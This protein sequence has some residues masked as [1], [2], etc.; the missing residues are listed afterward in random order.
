MITTEAT[1]KPTDECYTPPWVFE[2]L[3]IEFDLD[4]CAPEGGPPHVPA[5]RFF[6]LADD[7]LTS[8]WGNGR[9]WMNPP[10]SKPQPWIERFVEHHNG[11][12]LVPFSK[13]RWFNRLWT[14]DA[15]MVIAP[16]NMK[17]VKNGQP[18]GIFMPT[19][20]VAFGEECTAALYRME[21]RV[22]V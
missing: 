4:V 8:D 5:K 7:G 11:I 2:S 9:V 12:C 21:Y 14:S 18:H 6:S 17:F 22:R 16:S 13:A 10:Y 3:G 1:C 15:A 20:F 19:V